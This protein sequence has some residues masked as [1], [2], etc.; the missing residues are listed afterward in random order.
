MEPE[1]IALVVVGMHRSG[2]SAVTRVLNFLGAEIPNKVLPPRSGNPAGYWESKDLVKL[3][4][5]VLKGANASWDDVRALPDFSTDKALRASYRTK[6]CE[7]I[8]REFEDS[9]LVVIK[10]PRISRFVPL[11]A[12]ALTE[13]GFN[14]GF[15]ICVRNPVEVAESLEVRDGFCI[16]KSLLLWLDHTLRAERTTRKY[17]R[18]FVL[19]DELL[20]NWSNSL[21]V[22]A[23][24]LDL[25]FPDWNTANEAFIES[26]LRPNL[27]HHSCSEDA[28][29]Q[30]PD[31]SEWVKVTYQC[32]REL[33][34]CNRDSGVEKRLDEVSREFARAQGAFASLLGR[35][36]PRTDQ[37][38][39]EQRSAGSRSNELPPPE[40]SHV[41]RISSE[42]STLRSEMAA[43]RKRYRELS[44]RNEDAEQTL[45]RL[46]INNRSVRAEVE[47]QKNLA[48]MRLARVE[49]LKTEQADLHATAIWRATRPLRIVSS[50]FSRIWGDCRVA[51]AMLHFARR[52]GLRRAKALN[53]D[54]KLLRDSILFDEKYYKETYSDI[55]SWPTDPAMHYLIH[56]GKEGRNPHPL[57]DSAW[58][59]ETYPDV[60]KAK[61]NPL[62]HF[63]MFGAREK[64]NPHPFFDVRWYLENNND[65]ADNGINPLVHFLIHGFKEGRS[66]NPEF[67]CNLYIKEHPGLLEAATNPLVHY[68]GELGQKSPSDA[69]SRGADPPPFSD[70]VI[71][72]AGNPVPPGHT[73][74]RIATPK[75][76]I[77]QTRLEY[78]AKRGRLA[79]V[80]T[81]KTVLMVAHFVGDRL[82]GA[83]RSFL[84]ILDGL[85]RNDINIV[86][87]LPKDVSDYT[88]KV[89][90]RCCDCV[91][92]PYDWWQK[93]RPVSTDAILK[94]ETL[95]HEF[96][97][98][99]VHVNTIMLREPLV[100]A[101]NCAVPSIVHV[102]ELILDDQWLA[103]AIGDTPE[104]V[105]RQVLSTADWIIANSAATRDAFEKKSSTFVIPNPVDLAELDIPVSVDPESVRFGLISSNI[106]KKGIEDLVE[107]ARL[108]EDS[109]PNA[110]FVLVGPETRLVKNLEME[111]RNGNA[112]GNIEFAGYAPSPR[113]G[114]EKVDIVLNLSHFKESFGRTVVEAMAAR[115]PVIVYD[116]GALPEL[117]VEGETGFLVPYRRP[118]LAV[119]II[120]DLCIDPQRIRD[121]G[122]A[123]RKRAEIGYS[124]Q[125]FSNRLR[126]AYARIFD[127][128]ERSSSTMLGLVEGVH[129]GELCT[130]ETA[131]GGVEE[132]H[133]AGNGQEGGQRS[134][135]HPRIRKSLDPD[136]IPGARRDDTKAVDVSVIVP[137][138]N[139]ADYLP[140]RLC[141]IL[142]QTVLP[143]EIVFIDDASSDESV[144]VARGILEQSD[145]PFRIEVNRINKGPYANWRKGFSL[146]KGA[147]V[148]IAEADDTCESDFLETVFGSME[149]DSDVVIS[150]CQSRKI[151]ASG[152]LIDANSFAHTNEISRSKW[153]SSYIELGVREVV[154]ALIYRNTIPN[155]SASILKRSVA[156]EASPILDG[157]RYCGD[158]AFYARML[159]GGRIA[160]CRCSLNS[161][162]RHDMSQTRRALKSPEF[163]IEVARV[164]ES[165]CRDFPVRAVQ[166]PRMD[167]FL[168]NDYPVDGVE[169]NSSQP[170]VARHI[171]S[172]ARYAGKRKMIAFVTTNN[173]SHTGG[174]EVLWRE[175]A[176][177]FRNR[178]H[179]IVALTRNWDPPPVFFRE[180]ERAG[181]KLYFKE[182][183]GWEQVLGHDPD[184]VIVSTGDQ[185]EGT[186]YFLD[187]IRRDIDFVVVN[188]LTKE[189][190]FWPIRSEKLA[191]VREGYTNAAR[192]FFTCRNNHRVMEDRLKCS[193]NNVDYHFNPFHV[194]RTKVPEFPDT[195][196]GFR[197]AVPSKLLYIHKGQDLLIEVVKEGKWRGR[198]VQIN[199][200]GVGA[201]REKMEQSVAS[202][203]IANLVF[204]GRVADISEIWKEN[205]SILMPS[206]MEGLPI[207]LVSAML[208]A[209][210]PIVTDVGGHAELVEDGL[211]G[212][213][214]PN[215]DVASIDEAMERAWA[216]R[217]QWQEFGERARARVLDFL[218]A[219]PVADFL[220]KIACVI[221][222]GETRG[223]AR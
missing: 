19:Y 182:D 171:E 93:N 76:T 98:N 188:Q 115:R 57:F 38:F 145:L 73:P 178:G 212:F 215:P 166:F 89:C 220:N 132:A 105:V 20:E 18:S 88:R 7:I 51:K 8:A 126:Q 16:G 121:I 1:K 179:D 134:L 39:R 71:H 123:A 197:I 103:R 183:A 120:R 59:L 53:R 213:I 60:A 31:V 27:R 78:T 44:E 84:D 104:K 136:D 191:A 47:R 17:R 207:M 138:Y 111:Q 195:S 122:A 217:E 152:D 210:V 161:F 172:A 218:P 137:N 142:K 68:A 119:P 114:M 143:R 33:G 4:D 131:G 141:S 219:D 13:F 185:D 79:R 158:W 36:W 109:I 180:F 199:I 97:V 40:H 156:I 85:S 55:A 45:L 61:I 48:D 80:E 28:L 187:C 29:G 160:Y 22:V 192:V 205:H 15:V 74:E 117:V 72:S 82:F 163:V 35:D 81:R 106:R 14:P 153:K 12:G 194:D 140:E 86:V 181:I 6:F 52:E 127:E 108:C 70:D 102:R 56:G 116:W 63:L 43:L 129:G 124:K 10:D 25:T 139:Y 196:S 94:F 66:P 208:S 96:R 165:I 144:E 37:K 211:S 164:R 24:D 62:K 9:R 223:S 204:R 209:R 154:D 118:E 83:E 100:A 26:F 49:A 216:V 50:A 150:Y 34:R 113:A 41:D 176:I 110:V 221:D 23:S 107:I 64:R 147:Y 167:R 128:S 92:F 200:Y 130:Y 151:D 201:D 11:T 177:A 155:V 77:D 198:N 190:R 214:A 148:W 170:A 202:L 173:G 162:R 146:S 69:N 193:L 90:E 189:E 91:I 3:H 75:G 135:N 58:Y 99:L 95:I 65:V 42:L 32:I 46:R 101:T 159:L 125:L 30:R 186:E 206:R 175:A 21:R 149:N 169:T 222:A 67:D 87:A 168:N 2:T 133:P 203:G 112:P 184:L 157:Y 54:R 5:S 174:S